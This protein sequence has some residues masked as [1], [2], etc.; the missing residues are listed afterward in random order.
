MYLLNAAGTS[1]VEVTPLSLREAAVA[2]VSQGYVL[3]ASDCGRL[4][5]QFA[6]ASSAVTAL[7]LRRLTFP[8]SLDPSSRPRPK[9][10]LKRVTLPCRLAQPLLGTAEKWQTFF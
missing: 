2:L 4:R 10:R 7:G 3:D 1:R 9:A 6:R 8:R 5:D